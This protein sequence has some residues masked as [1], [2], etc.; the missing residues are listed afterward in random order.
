MMPL[1]TITFLLVYQSRHPVKWFESYYNFNVRQGNNMKPAEEMVGRHF[2]EKPKY[3]EHLAML[4]KTRLVDRDEYELLGL[5]R[6]VTPPLMSNEVFMYEVSQPFDH[7]RTR[8]EI[9]TKDISNFI[10]LSRPL[11]PIVPRA[12]KGGNYHYAIDVC[13]DKYIQLREELMAVSRNASQWISRYFLDHPDVTVS[14]KEHFR[15]DILASWM[16]DPCAVETRG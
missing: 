13:D 4:G 10:G 15:N 5:D 6:P 7:N 1:L 9:Y 8:A 16:T 11:E 2:S 14:S 3:H 12:S